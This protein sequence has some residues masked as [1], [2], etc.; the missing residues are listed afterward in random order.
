MEKVHC[1]VRS[2]C[3]RDKKRLFFIVGVCSQ[4][5]GMVYIADGKLHPL[6]KPKKKNLRHLAVLAAADNVKTSFSEGDDEKLY[7]FLQGFEEVL[8]GKDRS[9]VCKN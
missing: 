4:E 8:H 1:V 2:V 6:S 9:Q 3:G 7:R 5:K